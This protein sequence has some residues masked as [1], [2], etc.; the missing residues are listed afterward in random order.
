MEDVGVFDTLPNGFTPKNLEVT[1]GGNEWTEGNHFTF[2]FA[3]DTGKIEINF[4]QILTEKV[5][6]TYTTEMILVR[7]IFQKEVSS[8]ASLE[9]IP[10]NETQ[11]VTKTGTATFTPDEYTQNN[12]F[13]NGSYN[14]ET[15]EI[16]WRIGVNY[17]KE[18]LKN[19]EV[20]DIIQGEQNFDLNK[21][22]VYK[23]EL[24]GEEK[25]YSKGE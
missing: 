17:N 7:R 9:W 2:D 16:T 19:V 3:E 23:M 12:G 6:I 25:G 15:K 13:K 22:A 1:H 8:I 4:N 5:V 21:V 24:T 10:E 11:K 18:T 20:E 14:P